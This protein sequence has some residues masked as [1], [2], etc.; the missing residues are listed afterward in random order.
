MLYNIKNKAT[1]YRDSCYATIFMLY[2][3]FVCCKT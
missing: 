3:K 1:Y 2:N